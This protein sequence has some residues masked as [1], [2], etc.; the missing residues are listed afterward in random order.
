[1]SLARRGGGGGG[2]GGEQQK[3]IS[4]THVFQLLAFDPLTFLE[5]IKREEGDGVAGVGGW[6]E[7]RGQNGR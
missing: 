5:G 1:M 7:G 6:G 2:G 3:G 4:I